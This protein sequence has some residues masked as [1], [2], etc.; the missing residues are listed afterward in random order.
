V[1]NATIL[2]L[3]RPSRVSASLAARLGSPVLEPA[4]VDEVLDRYGLRARGAHRNLRLA[5]RS[6][7]VVVR[8]DR[9]TKVV[10]R[11]R[12]Q[13]TEETV[14]TGHSVLSRLAE[15][16]VPA[17]RLVRAPGGTTWVSVDGQVFAVFDHVP[18]T[19]YSLNFLLR[20][21]R[22]WLTELAGRTLARLHR[23]LVGF[24]PTGRHHMGFASPTGPRR[25]DAAWHATKLEELQRR[26]LGLG[27][28]DATPYLIRLRGDA[29]YLLDAIERLERR[30]A[31]A[32]FPR[33]VIHGDYGLHNLIFQPTGRDVTETFSAGEGGWSSLVAIP[34]DFEMSR[35]D[36]RINDLISA[37][38]KHRY[39]GGR[40]DNESMETFLAA[41]AAGFPLT[42]DERQM[43]PSAWRLHKL[44]AAVQY[45]NS[46]FETDGPIRKLAS[47]VDAIEQ[48]DLV[49][50]RPEVI[51]SLGRF[52]GEVTGGPAW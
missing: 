15:L 3:P 12:P 20:S 5:R 47:A 26:S 14:R 35:L 23:A 38:G 36:W 51:R 39:R 37:L 44:Q 49:L 27:R 2:H 43:L 30:L 21:D 34:V 42:R 31:D 29:G 6:L 8:T 10:K 52:A 19:N 9:G 40:Y 24:I 22:L 28:P 33:L 50:E 17:V 48:A 32:S 45:W 46:Y 1:S 4:R 25:R 7:N 18:G 41:Y 16:A 11:Y 13:W